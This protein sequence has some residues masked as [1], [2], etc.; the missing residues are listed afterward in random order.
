M[1]RDEKQ[2]AGCK[3]EIDAVSGRK[4]SQK[5]QYNENDRWSL[6]GPGF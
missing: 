6:E 4:R 3:I 1:A 5:L 2:H